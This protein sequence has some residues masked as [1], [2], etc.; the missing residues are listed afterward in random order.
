MPAMVS[1]ARRRRC[2]CGLWSRQRRVV[3]RCRKL[4]RP[5]LLVDRAEPAQ[6]LLS[7]AEVGPDRE[8][9]EYAALVT[10][11]D[12]EIL[13]LGQLYRDRGDSENAFDELKNQWG[14]A[15]LPRTT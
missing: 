3:P 7:F 8:V 5:L 14:G 12:S 15:V 10:S 4:D 6:P 2:G 1:R 11:L 13:T 9:W